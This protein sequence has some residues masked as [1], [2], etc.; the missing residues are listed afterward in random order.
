[1][2]LEDLPLHLRIQAERQLDPSPRAQ[3]PASPAPQSTPPPSGSFHP[4]SPRSPV[5][6][7]LIDHHGNPNKTEQDYNLKHLNG[8]GRFEPLI[9]RLP[10]GNYTPD[11]M[12]IEDGIVTLHEC[13]GSYRFDS[14]SRAILAFKS[15]A[16]MFPFWRFVWATK[17][18]SGKWDI[19]RYDPP[20][21]LATSPALS[22]T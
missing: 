6:P 2:R 21:P 10:G 17:T 15:A 12:T 1:M 4:Y 19:K 11:W 13:K 9:L 16:A 3:K 7:P 8:Q 20:I 5:S 22:T 18:K 14:Q